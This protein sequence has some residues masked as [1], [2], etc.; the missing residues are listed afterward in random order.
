MCS[1]PVTS[2][3]ATTAVTSA[4]HMLNTVLSTTSTSVAAHTNLSPEAYAPSLPTVAG[5]AEFHSRS[6]SS[7]SLLCSSVERL[8]SFSSSVLITRSLI[9][10]TVPH[11]SSTRT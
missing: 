5:A 9:P 8:P 11:A 6:A 7:Q 2:R 1:E 4:S 3:I 10:F